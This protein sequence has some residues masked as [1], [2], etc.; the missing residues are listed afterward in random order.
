MLL[1][2]VDDKNC[3]VFFCVFF[4][5]SGKVSKHS[6]EVLRLINFLYERRR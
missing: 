5:F 3:I 2:S 4:R 1:E 6:V